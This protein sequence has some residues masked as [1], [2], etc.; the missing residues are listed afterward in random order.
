MPDF[1]PEATRFT[2]AL[3]QGDGGRYRVVFAPAGGLGWSKP[4]C[5]PGHE[6]EVDASA[7]GGVI[8]TFLLSRHLVATPS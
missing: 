6:D 2:C 1:P 3:R 8:L 4:C 7:H 5:E